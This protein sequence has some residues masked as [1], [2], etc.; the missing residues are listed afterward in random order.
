[1]KVKR[2]YSD[3]CNW[4]Y[5]IRKDYRVVKR[6]LS[7][8]DEDVICALDADDNLIGTW[9]CETQHGLWYERKYTND[10]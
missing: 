2:S 6:E 5:D 7:T 3:Y 8:D 10:L 4:S 9:D 1:M